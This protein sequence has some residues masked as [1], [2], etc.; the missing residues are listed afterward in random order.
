MHSTTSAVAT[1]RR[2]SRPLATLTL[3]AIVIGV[4]VV[5]MNAGAFRGASVYDLRAIVLTLAR[6]DDPA[7]LPLV[8][9]AVVLVCGWAER[10]MGGARMLFAYACGGVATSVAGLAVGG[11]ETN[12]F[13]AI[14]L[15]ETPVT[16]A[17]P[18]PALLGVA[19]AASCFTDA[20]WRRRVRG[21]CLVSA[22]TVFLYAASSS[23]LFSLLALPVGLGAGVLLGGRRAG[24]R[25]QRSSHH[26]VRVLLC[27]L[28]A[29][30]AVGPI[31]ATL[32]GSGAGLLSVYG[33]LSYD[34]LV[35]ADGVM[36][37]AGSTFAP[38]PDAAS[39]HE[40]QASAGWI[41][42]LPLV[43]LLVAAW[44]ILRGRMA[45]L[46]VAIAVNLLVFAGMTALFVVSEPDMLALLAQVRGTDASG[47]WQSLVGLLAAALVPLGVAVTLFV[48][49]HSVSVA[50]T[51]RAV[52]SFFA[53]ISIGAAAVSMLSLVG[54]L[55]AAADF[56]PRLTMGE[57]LRGI[58]LR[59]LPPSLLPGG[60]VHGVPLTALSQALWYLPSAVFW[61]VCVAA[62]ARLVLS[63]QSVQGAEDR[64]RAREML[65]RGCGSLGFM[66]TWPG[67]TYWFAGDADAGFAY[68]LHGG[69]AVTL[70]G[71]FGADRHR[72][73][74]GAAFVEF[75][76][77][78]GWI[79]VFYSVDEAAATALDALQ[80][81]R[82]RVADEAVLDPRT[83]TP[84][85]KKRQDVR[86]ATNRA[87]REGVRAQWVSWSALTLIDRVQIREIS[88]AWV[89][90]K[91]I[92][93]MGFTLGT[94]DE[95]ADPAARLMLA[96]DASQRI[97][98]VT[99]WI[100]VFGE[101]GLTGY[102]LDVMRRRHDAM[103]GIMEFLI[104]AVVDQLRADDRTL[105]SL[106][107]SPLAP[108]RGDDDGDLSAVDRFLETLSGV[109]EPA[110]GFRSLAHFKNK[111]Q[112]HFCPLWIVYPD[113]IHLPAIALA[114]LR[115]YVPGLS[116]AGAARLAVGMRTSRRPSPSSV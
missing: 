56:S 41:A 88:E 64:A 32:W 58:P 15:G 100:P 3:A 108:H 99:T 4:S 67:N 59:L 78:N 34:P 50:P 72:E 75:C 71:A 2:R 21:A 113:A 47:A 30:T 76:G 115:C 60:W 25:G 94:V 16:G 77:D 97:V 80:W 23:D 39:Y 111:F 38:C 102:A 85:G 14:P 69:V 13:P 31:V 9:I 82:T 20:L 112:P 28:T 107:G 24:M 27:A 101:E 90:D 81:R 104:G 7:T 70:G 44:G 95:A 65:Q 11:W 5:S 45:A 18:V 17:T 36:C 62:T 92:P 52:G 12:V 83:W 79:P 109:L 63:R 116:L 54:G 68:R 29:I 10:L 87:H 6:V 42:A 84:A 57:V 89:A 26:E 1:N 8:V 37:A 106:S 93:E 22:V 19:M 55:L 103:N 49:R 51:K 46:A 40:V 110:Y 43:V 33:W 105:L 61:T 91:S 48:C 98:A 53:S 96:R 114:L 66:A 35:V 86:T 74:I 73:E